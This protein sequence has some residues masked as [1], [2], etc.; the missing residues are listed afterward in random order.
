MQ[1][2]LLA[3]I[4]IFAGLTG[5]ERWELARV[6]TARDVPAREV[7]FWVGDPGAEF[8]IISAG[9]VEI[10][11]PDQA[12]R[13]M[14]LAVLGPGDFLGEIALL[15]GGTRTATARARTDATLLCLARSEFLA[16]I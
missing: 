5:D 15:D 14:T 2:E 3:G 8:F 1:F 4:P 6:V 13:E 12:G 7:L 16:F 10:T 9:Q 11:V